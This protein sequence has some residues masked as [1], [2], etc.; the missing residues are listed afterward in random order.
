M[1][2]VTVTGAVVLLINAPLIFPDPLAAIPVTDALLSLVQL[3]TVPATGEPLSTIV[4]IVAELQI[5]WAAGVA[6]AVGLPEMLTTT[7]VALY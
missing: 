6:V 3:Y 4:V 5:V 1:V 2:N 7:D